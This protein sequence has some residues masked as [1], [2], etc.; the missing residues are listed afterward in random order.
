MNATCAVKL[1]VS[2]ALKLG[3]TLCKDNRNKRKIIR[4]IENILQNITD[5]VV[6]KVSVLFPGWVFWFF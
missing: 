2:L 6:L 4:I 1:C 5:K 3:P